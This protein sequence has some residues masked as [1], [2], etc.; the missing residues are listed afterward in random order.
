M[1]RMGMK[2]IMGGGAAIGGASERVA[3]AWQEALARHGRETQLGGDLIMGLTIHIADS[4]EQAIKEAT[5]YYEE[6]VKMFAPLGFVRG[7]NEDQIA[8]AADPKRA[9]SGNL[10]TMKDQIT[11]G[12]WLVGP[13]EHLVETLLDIQDR[14]PG[15]TEVNV[16]HPVGTPKRVVLEQLERFA[17]EVMPAFLKRSQAAPVAAG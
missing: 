4:E 1:A 6:W 17:T 8:A 2:G 11:A 7:L 16:G 13:P 5:P 15:L 10:P 12:S 3:K 14:W 9:R